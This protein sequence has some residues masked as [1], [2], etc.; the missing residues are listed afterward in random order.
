M[1]LKGFA[2]VGLLG[3]VAEKRLSACRQRRGVE[4]TEPRNNFLDGRK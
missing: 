2:E 3:G 1:A 4:V